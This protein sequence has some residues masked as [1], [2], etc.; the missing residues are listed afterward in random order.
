MDEAKSWRLTWYEYKQSDRIKGLD[1]G[2]SGKEMALY[3]FL[4]LCLFSDF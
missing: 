4:I 3:K 2:G 1:G